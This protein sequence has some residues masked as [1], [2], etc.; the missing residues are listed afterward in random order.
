MAVRGVIQYRGAPHQKMRGFK[1]AVKAANIDAV[2][3]WHEEYLPVH[4][5]SSAPR[6]YRYAKRVGEGEPETRVS[7]YTIPGNFRVRHSARNN[8]YYWRKKRQKGHTLPLVWSGRSKRE[9]IRRIRVTGTSKSASGTM[10]PP[11]YFYMYQKPGVYR[12]KGGD[13]KRERVI[14]RQ[15][16]DKADEATRI[17]RE[18]ARSLA[19]VHRVSLTSRLNKHNPRSS[20]KV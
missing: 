16:I 9:M 10:Y 6:K 19:S 17:T 1:S 12:V 8:A 5:T 18:E 14:Y 13:G 2:E 15:P 3:E 11:R 4:F 20:R 7:R